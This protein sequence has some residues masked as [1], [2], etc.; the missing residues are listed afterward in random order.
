MAESKLYNQK[1]FDILADRADTTV[2]HAF[3]DYLNKKQLEPTA[4]DTSRAE[5][6][7]EWFLQQIVGLHEPFR[8]VYDSAL[9]PGKDREVSLWQC[10][11]TQEYPGKS[12]QI[13]KLFVSR[14]ARH[15][16]IV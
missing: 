9:G 5:D 2:K 14:L 1:L 11:F 7:D 16:R 10:F 4:L 15:R 3:L 8:V 13:L 12:G 6:N